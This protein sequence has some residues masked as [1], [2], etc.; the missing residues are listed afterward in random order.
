M[1]RPYISFIVPVYGVESYL[2]ECIDSIICQQGNWELIL[3]DDGSPDKC[4]E[5][6][7]EYAGRNGRIRVIHKANGGVSTARNAGLD[8]AK[9]EWIWFVDA[10]DIIDSESLNFIDLPPN[11]DYIMFDYQI[12]K[13]GENPK[14]AQ[15]DNIE[16]HTCKNKNEFLLK[17]IC[18]HHQSL[19]Y[20]RDIIETYHLRFTDGLKL[21]EDGEF[22]FK[23]LMLC[24]YTI[25]I[26]ACFYFYRI[27]QGSATQS[28]MTRE[29]IVNDTLLALKNL[30]LFMK[31][32]DITLER[33]LKIRI[34]G[35]IQIL[36]YSASQVAS[37]NIQQ[38]QN[39]F[40]KVIDTY[41]ATGYQILKKLLYK[42]A[43]WN[44][45]LY[46]ISLKIYL[47]AKGIK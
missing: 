34:E 32:Y 33:W 46:F 3:V 47:K 28:E 36:L 44:V 4:P 15:N 30:L 9:G 10:D 1:N 16:I 42:L 18:L 26:D 31:K 23:Y 22:Q 6:C 29:Q 14:K 37:L 8:A 7:D 5:I 17:Y 13:D 41:H 21:G 27:R 35:T 11:K 38:F 12:F 39:E 2:R 43:Y 19:W 24:K 25:K 20:K 40:R 45:K